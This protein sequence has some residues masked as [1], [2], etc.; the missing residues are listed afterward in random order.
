MSSFC[1]NTRTCTGACRGPGKRLHQPTA[2]CDLH[3][4]TPR[5]CPAPVTGAALAHVVRVPQQ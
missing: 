5:R 2:Q 4:L 3:P 1:S